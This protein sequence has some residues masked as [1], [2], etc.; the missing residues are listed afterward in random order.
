MQAIAA[1]TAR[2]EFSALL[3]RVAAGESFRIT[4]RGKVVAR[5]EPEAAPRRAPADV[6]AGVF[7]L[8]DRGIVA[9]G[10]DPVAAGRRRGRR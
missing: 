10:F 1:K 7:A 6:M 8:H 9:D 3:R 2:L 5:L 4:R